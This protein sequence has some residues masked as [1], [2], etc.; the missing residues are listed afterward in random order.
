[1]AF[2]AQP[3]K[4]EIPLRSSAE[5][6]FDA[7]MVALFLWARDDFFDFVDAWATWLT[8]NSTVIGGELNDTDIGQTTPAA[9]AFTTL[10]A[11]TLGG[12]ALL[13]TVSEA[14]GVPTGS[15][16]EKGSNANGEYVRFADGTQLCW[17]EFTAELAINTALMGGF[18]SLDMTWTFPAAFAGVPSASAFPV[19]FSA[20]GVTS[21][22]FGSGSSVDF[23]LTSV[24]TQASAT[25]R[26][27]AFAAGR[28][29]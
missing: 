14:A 5:A 17:H 28:W 3:A 29:F 20:F 1:M 15:I 26:I 23:N 24:T 25:R 4:P 21:R 6:D 16:L 11:N 8:E 9:G 7:K 10:A 13:G 22:T 27:R 2:P 19:S 18:R 12:S